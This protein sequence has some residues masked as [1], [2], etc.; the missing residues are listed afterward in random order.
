MRESSDVV[1]GLME[2]VVE[3]TRDPGEA[4]RLFE[5]S[6]A[7]ADVLRQ[8]DDCVRQLHEVHAAKIVV[9]GLDASTL[10]DLIARRR[11]RWNALG[12]PR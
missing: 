2:C 12:D 8:L 3:D 7:E 6:G 10:R 1:S 9:A 11:Q 5:L 4:E